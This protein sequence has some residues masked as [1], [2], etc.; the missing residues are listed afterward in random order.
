MLLGG[1]FFLYRMEARLIVLSTVQET[2]TAKLR[3][4]ETELKKLA[5][6]TIEIARQDERMT[7]QDLR[8]NTIALRLDE[9]LRISKEAR[10]VPR[11]GRG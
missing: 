8:I 9:Y 2:F 7:S 6:V 11:R 1:L 3:E 10:Q 5:E 4:M